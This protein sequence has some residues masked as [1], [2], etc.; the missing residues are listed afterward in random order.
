M[1]RESVER[2]RHDRRLNRRREWVSPED[3][4][5]YL[6]GLPDLTDK[7]IRGS[8]D[9]EEEVA[10]E[11]ASDSAQPSFSSAPE[12]SATSAQPVPAAPGT[13]ESPPTPIPFGSSA[14][15]SSDFSNDGGENGSGF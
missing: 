10:A 2:L 4:Q 14:S 3:R 8:E 6:D 11:G 13:P 7:M 5:S 9:E 15:P 1:D 12:T